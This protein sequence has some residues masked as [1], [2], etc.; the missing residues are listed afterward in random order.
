MH[1]STKSGPNG[2][3]MLFAIH[4]LISLPSELRTQIEDLGG[5]YIKNIFAKLFKT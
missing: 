2:Q 5:Q 3:A 1:N 4:D